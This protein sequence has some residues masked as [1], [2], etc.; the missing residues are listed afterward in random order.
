MATGRTDKTDTSILI[1]YALTVAAFYAASLFPEARLWGI[2]WYT[3]FGW[4]GPVV[5]LLA[6]LLVPLVLTFTGAGP[7][8]RTTPDH[9]RFAVTS[10]VIIILL[11]A[12]FYLLRGRTHFLGDG[13]QIIHWLQS[14]KP[15]DKPWAAG[16]DATLRWLYNIVKDFSTQP[17]LTAARIYS[18]VSGAIF[19]VGAAVASAQLFDRYRDRVILLVGLLSGGQMLLYFGYIESYPLFVTVVG[20]FNLMG[21]LV[22][23][24]KLRR[25]W[26]L[27]PLAAAVS[28][29]IFCV[30][31]LP[32]AVYILLRETALGR[33]L[34]SLPG[35][36]RWGSGIVFLAAAA[37]VFGYFYDTNYFFRFTIVPFVNGP[38]VVE[39][40]TMFS[41]AHLLDYANLLWQHAPALALF[42]VVLIEVP[43]GVLVKRPSYRFLLL[44]VLPSLAMVFI[45]QPGLGMPRD[46]DLFSF[47]AIPIILLGF[48]TVLD[49]R[50]R[51]PGYFQTSVLAISLA[52]MLL[53]PR[54]ITQA[55]PEKGIEV[56]ERMAA[57]DSIRNHAG[58][59][60][61][62]D[63]YEKH[64][65]SAEVERLRNFCQV[66]YPQERWYEEARILT[67]RGQLEAAV[68][69]LHDALNFDPTNGF[70]WAGL[71]LWYYDHQRLD[72]ALTCWKIAAAV[73]PFQPDNIRQLGIGYLAVG[74]ST[75]AEQCWLKAAAL[76]STDVS[77]RE[78]LL[79]LYRKQERTDE[80]IALLS[81]L[82]SRPDAPLGIVLEFADNCAFRGDFEASR[83]AFLRALAMGAD[84]S[85]VREREEYYPDLNIFGN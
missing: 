34:A 37:L 55:I 38:L 19:A 2:N 61:L 16:L 24:G 9:Q 30:A 35:A 49:N 43:L 36:V 51:L 25:A 44:L 22:V 50:D 5:L 15:S 28:L 85:F 83:K 62:I 69:R 64:G 20:L 57:L 29:H 45:F 84:T 56:F 42:L 72:S 6:G 21:L 7:D 10:A 47:P 65:D 52:L 1:A 74:D 82:A 13:Y 11:T 78:Y 67:E 70:A 53:I 76:D 41:A 31:L 39:R 48:Y 63:Y 75:R 8:D 27:I 58:R 46:W 66:E 14:G 23:R 81:L 33:R 4:Y 77:S 68:G 3:Y 59:F 54:V 73:N 60:I 18:Y 26:L 32:A 17:A 12:F 80:Y 71:G 79:A 40:Y